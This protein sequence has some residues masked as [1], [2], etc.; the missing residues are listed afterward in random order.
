[1]NVLFVLVLFS[2]FGMNLVDA[3]RF[4]SS[5]SNPPEGVDSRVLTLIFDLENRVKNLED[6]RAEDV[7]RMSNMQQEID[8]LKY[9]NRR[10]QHL[11]YH[12]DVVTLKSE[13]E[14]TP[15]GYRYDNDELGSRTAGSIQDPALNHTTSEPEQ[16]EGMSIKE[17]KASLFRRR[18]RK[19][20]S[21]QKG[22]TRV[23]LTNTVIAF[24]AI[25]G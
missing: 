23:G 20:P 12:R 9:E 8:E 5:S 3:D 21:I 2:G 18:L 13:T 7:R 1:M 15:I 10:L 16:N 25:L 14:K 4:G 22:F 17:T 11:S 19:E 6:T 24:H